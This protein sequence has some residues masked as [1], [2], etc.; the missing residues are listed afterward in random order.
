M[1]KTDSFSVALL[2]CVGACHRGADPSAAPPAAKVT[3]ARPENSLAVVSLAES[4]IKRLGIETAVVERRTLKAFLVAPGEVVSPPGKSLV[5][6]APMAGTLSHALLRT[7]GTLVSQGE[8]IVRLIPLPSAT[9][10]ASAQIR[11]DAARK[12][13][14]RTQVLLKDGAGSQRGLEEAEA[15]LAMAQANVGASSGANADGQTAILQLKA[16]FSGVIRDVLVGAGQVVAAG[17]PLFQIDAQLNLWVRAS[18]YVGD[19]SRVDRTS[20]ARAFPLS[21][22]AKNLGVDVMS[23]V[24]PPSANAEAA[25]E[26]V[27]YQLPTHDAG[28]VNSA[29]FHPRQRI[30]VNVPLKEE[31][32]AL[33][34]PWSSVLFDAYGGTWVYLETSPGS[35]IRRK[36]QVRRVTGGWAVLQRG[37]TAGDRV[38][39][40]GAAEL[41]GTEF[42]AG[43]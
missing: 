16:P 4:A 38:V 25:S 3:G 1:R 24:G 39:S 29:D 2:F 8:T 6:S 13:R 43:K 30:S 42:G 18:L 15:E 17:A 35:Y 19:V 14:D 31:A 10:L 36:I 37:L 34:V 20:A 27:F 41:F 23:V 9:D 32:L 26:D 5:I 28:G 11:L 12:R 21:A 33:V 22:N 40:V 7:P